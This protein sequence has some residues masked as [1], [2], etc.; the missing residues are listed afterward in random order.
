M[1][2]KS[3]RKKGVGLTP[4]V[5]AL[6]KVFQPCNVERERKGEEAV[7]FEYSRY[8][9]RNGFAPHLSGGG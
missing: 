5:T 1:A 3:R 6:R 2:G 9:R 4:Q 7:H 8:L